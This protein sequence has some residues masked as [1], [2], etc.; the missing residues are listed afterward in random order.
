L[1]QVEVGFDGFLHE[2]SQLFIQEID[3]GLLPLDV[4]L[5]TSRA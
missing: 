4:D 2:A 5:E 3:R 1:D